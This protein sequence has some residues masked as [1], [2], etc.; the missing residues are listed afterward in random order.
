MAAHKATANCAYGSDGCIEKSFALGIVNYHKN[1]G[2]YRW[3]KNGVWDAY[4]TTDPLIYFNTYDGSVNFVRQMKLKL[5]FDPDARTATLT[6]VQNQE[7]VDVVFTDTYT[8]VDLRELCGSDKAYLAFTTDAGGRSTYGAIDNLKVVNEPLDGERATIAAGSMAVSGTPHMALAG[9]D[10]SLSMSRVLPSGL[11][12][13]LMD[14]AM[15]RTVANSVQEIGKDK[16]TVDGA[17]IP[18]GVYTSENCEWIEGGGR[19]IV[20]CAGTMIVIK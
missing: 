5:E 12:F 3:G 18:I 1:I 8:N 19:V 14:G 11:G 6:L 20:G 7:G 16:L 13:D 10:L 15:F 9:V 17:I 2:Q 4:K